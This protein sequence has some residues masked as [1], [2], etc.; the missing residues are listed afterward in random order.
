MRQIR[1]IALA[2]AS[3]LAL[4]LLMGCNP[5]Q[6]SQA[7]VPDH[8]AAQATAAS[9]SDGKHVAVSHRFS[10]RLPGGEIREVHQKHLAEC[11]RLG[12]QVLSTSLDQSTKGRA[13]ARSSVRISPKAF[14]DFE[15]AISAPPAEV[16]VRTETAEDK[17]LPILDVEKRLEVKSALRDRLTAMV[18]EPGQKSAADIASIERQIADL[19]GEIEAAIAQRDYLR[20]ITETVRVDIDYS[21]VSARAGGVNFSPI[22]DALTGALDTFIQSTASVIVFAIAAA[23]W[24]PLAILALWAIRRVRRRSRA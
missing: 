14:P 23:P 24:I 8:L 15:R 6:S 13:Q 5:Q 7:P 19:Q 9:Q 22:A 2:G 17:S 21:S 12:C 16:A 1:P 4:L 3:L 11:R 20:T 10:L 18:K